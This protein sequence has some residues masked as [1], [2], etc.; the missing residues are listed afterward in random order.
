MR[1]VNGC[2]VQLGGTGL[3]GRYPEASEVDRSGPNLWCDLG[4]WDIFGGVIG[5]TTQC[6]VLVDIWYAPNEY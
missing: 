6:T 3:L 4:N 5:I 2:V 1:S